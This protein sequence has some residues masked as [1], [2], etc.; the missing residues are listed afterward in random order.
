MYDTQDELSKCIAGDPLSGIVGVRP[1]RRE[2]S[3]KK[4]AASSVFDAL[5]RD[6]LD[7]TLKPGS[8]LKIDTLCQSYHATINPVREAL[9]RLTAIGLVDLE[10]QRGFSV[11]P[12]SLD[13]WREI[14]RSRCLVEACAL[15]EAIANRTE[16]WEEGIVL[17]LY[18]LQK[19]P[20]FLEGEQQTANPEWEPR[21]HTF[22]NALLLTCNARIVLEFCE[23][24]RER[25]DRYRHIASISPHARQSYGSEHAE[26]AEATLAGDADRAVQLL[27]GH[28]MRTLTVVENFL[29][30]G[31]EKGPGAAGSQR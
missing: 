13:E 27:T 23:E 24:L 11:S 12:V 30:P 26:I 25:S 14:V 28:Y 21:H 20:R 17:S 4:T 15:R 7:G 1:G 16:A 22:H 5:R 6:I 31:E 9:N 18:R 10:D 8:R 29:V 2:G 19:T 3:G